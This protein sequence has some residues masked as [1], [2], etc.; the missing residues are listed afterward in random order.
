MIAEKASKFE[1]EKR[2][3]I[4][5]NKDESFEFDKDLID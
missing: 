3:S 2:I 5:D 1:N 4:D